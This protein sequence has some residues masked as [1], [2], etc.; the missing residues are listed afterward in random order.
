M[1][2]SKVIPLGSAGSLSVSEEGGVAQLSLSVSEAS[3]G[4]LA[5][6]GKASAS[7]QASVSAVALVDV[8]LGLASAKW[9]AAA[10]IL[11]SLEAII[12]A[13]ASKL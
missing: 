9:P 12:A 8:L 7:V 6:V 3:A 10:P 5:G 11:E 2:Y 1:S 4:S 13:E